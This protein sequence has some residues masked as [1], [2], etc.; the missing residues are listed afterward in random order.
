MAGREAREGNDH[1]PDI[2]PAVVLDGIIRA[3]MNLENDP[4]IISTGGALTCSVL[5]GNVIGRKHKS[6]SSQSRV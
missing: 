6:G 2:K 3:V 5:I 4:T 1:F